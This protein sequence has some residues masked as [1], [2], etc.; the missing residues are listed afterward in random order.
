M[1]R[2]IEMAVSIACHSCGKTL[3]EG[4]DLISPYYVRAKNNCRC[5]DCGRK[6]S[7]T[8]MSV[9]LDLFRSKAKL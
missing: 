4:E 6:L 5:P 7:H 8:P 2:L 9:Q 3:F 1:C